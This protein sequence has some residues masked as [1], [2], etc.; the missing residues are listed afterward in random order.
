VQ[1]EDNCFLVLF[2]VPASTVTDTACRPTEWE[3]VDPLPQ[4]LLAR[5]G[6]VRPRRV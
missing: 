6:P 4:I 2:I 1:C 5:A 3:A